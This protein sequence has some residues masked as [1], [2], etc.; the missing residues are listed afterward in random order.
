MEAA[1]L[2]LAR[3][4]R[5][6]LSLPQ[7]NPLDYWH[8][9][10]PQSRC[11]IELLSE[12]D[13]IY[14]RAA[15]KSGKTTLA[16]AIVVACLQKRTHLDGIH[17]PRWKGPVHGLG[18]VLDY[19]Q[20]VL[21][22]QD[23]VL[24]AL[25]SW[26]FSPKYK[27]GS[28]LS[29]IAVAPIGVDRPESEWSTFHFLSQENRR[30]GVGARADIVWADEPPV[31]SI[32]RELRKAAHAGR[33]M[34]RLISATPT[35]RRQ[36]QWLRDD[37]GDC[38]RGQIELHP[39][40]AEV[41]WS[42]QDNSALTELEI[43]KL[44]R[45]YGR[46]RTD[47]AGRPRRDP[48]YEARV[49]G[50][51]VDAS[52]ACP[53]DLA[54]LHLMLEECRPGELRAVPITREV[55]GEDGRSRVVTTVEVEFWQGSRAGKSYYIPIDSSAGINDSRHDPGELHVVEVGSGDLVARFC[56]YIGGFGLGTLA[57]S[58]ARQYNNATIDPETTGGWG[59][60][61]LS[62]LAEARYGNIA[63]TRKE[64]QPGKWHTDL[65][66]K[67]TLHSRPLM[68]GAV[69]SWIEA[70]AAGIKY[71][72]C[73]SRAVIESLIDTVL[74]DHDKAVAAPGYHDEPLILRGQSLRKAVRRPSAPVQTTEKPVPDHNQRIA[75]IIQGRDEDD[76]AEP[77]YR[78]RPRI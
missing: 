16:A 17:L 71:A 5:V 15:N 13:E 48:L 10:S 36:W 69:Q 1:P 31:E 46:D 29:S 2:V 26:P 32:W 22:T 7:R 57:A 6:G 73:P 33:R 39:D 40:W 70:Y 53:F 35:I 12:K 74:D 38:P 67:T 55:D 3:R 75:A 27:G 63:K 28:I 52:G 23:A 77:I 56:G 21:S 64:L 37:Y 62:G 24:A 43:E 49:F 54:A 72:A 9:S 61:V 18:L 30:S 58:L 11:A 76:Y 50:D 60:V 51:Y 59:E 41:R 8:A 45:E 47:A 68:V 66:F 44:L 78:Q 19:T 42:L 20:Q 65:G 34:I 25:G 14:C 4:V